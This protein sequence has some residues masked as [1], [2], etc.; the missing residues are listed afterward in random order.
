MNEFNK[1]WMNEK[2]EQTFPPFPHFPRDQDWISQQKYC[3]TGKGLYRISDFPCRPECGTGQ[4]PVRYVKV[5]GKLLVAIYKPYRSK[6]LNA[7]KIHS[8]CLP[9]M[10]HRRLPWLLERPQCL[11]SE[12][13]SI[14]SDW[15]AD[16]D[17]FGS[18]QDASK[19]PDQGQLTRE[20]IRNCLKSFLS[21]HRFETLKVPS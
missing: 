7:E 17:Q 8:L 11:F 6:L 10:S 2:S 16:L 18:V 21:W 3:P 19:C 1:T 12:V 15:K 9:W 5:M 20:A 13:C 4:T 14:D